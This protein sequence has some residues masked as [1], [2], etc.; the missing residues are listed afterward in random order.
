MVF[1]NSGWIWLLPMAAVIAACFGWR[2]WSNYRA[3]IGGYADRR[4]LEG[5]S[6][7]LSPRRFAAVASCAV[8]S[9]VMACVACL[10]PAVRDEHVEFPQGTVD[11]IAVVDVSR[12]MAAQDYVGKTG[13]FEGGTRLD[14]CRHL[15]ATKLIPAL[16]CNTLGI[17]SYAG[18]AFDQSHLSTDTKVLTWL[19]EN[20]VT[21]SSAPG[22]GSNLWKAFTM[23]FQM[24]EA[25]S[26][27]GHQRLIVLFSD[28]G[29]DNRGDELGKVLAMAGQL[30]VKVMIVGVGSNNQSAIPTAQ[31]SERERKLYQG[32][33]HAF[34]KEG[35]EPVLTARD[36]KFMVELADGFHGPYVRVDD[37]DDFVFTPDDYALEV[38][39]KSAH[40]ELF[41]YPMFISLVAAVAAFVL[42]RFS[43]LRLR[44]AKVEE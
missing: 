17:V 16:R 15:M 42:L 31:L 21:V 37:P 41:R 12:S 10:R 7:P 34:L 29:C 25:D 27:A 43:E 23:A 2:A 22:D 6:K 18:E 24:F 26:P 4:L 36:E 1:L 9:V 8:L 30:N 44:R 3:S 39:Y 5:R 20:Q 13:V 28:G 33:P 32:T 14:M 38:V 11:V 35:S 40:R 19:V